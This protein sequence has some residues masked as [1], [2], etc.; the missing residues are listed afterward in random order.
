MNP[1]E[2]LGLSVDAAMDEVLAA[3]RDKVRDLGQTIQVTDPAYGR[4]LAIFRQA[5]SILT[6]PDRR[7]EFDATLVKNQALLNPADLKYVWQMVGKQYYDQTNRYTPAFDALRNSSPLTLENDN[8]LIVSID[9]SQGHLMGYL[10][11]GE[12]HVILKRILSDVCKRTMDFRVTTAT[13]MRDWN[14]LREAESKLQ[15][16]RSAIGSRQVNGRTSVATAPTATTDSGRPLLSGMAAP[17]PK[18]TPVAANGP[19]TDEWEEVMEGLMRVWSNTESRNFPQ[20]RARLILDSLEMISETEDKARTKNMPSDLFNR[21]LAR[22]LDRVGS[23]TGTDSAL[24]GVEYL[25]MRQRQGK[26]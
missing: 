3:F 24:I 8:L 21:A 7:K 18:P 23:L 11:A 1:Y 12:T 15:P 16:A 22:A 17:A 26:R 20:V 10:E 5:V 13:T 14:T 4:Q 25:N 9:P 6:D 2:V 19:Q